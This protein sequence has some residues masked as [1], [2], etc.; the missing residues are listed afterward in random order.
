MSTLYGRDGEGGGGGATTMSRSACTSPT[1][2]GSSRPALSSC[3]TFAAAA[4]PGLAGCAA[5]CGARA[6]Q[7]GHEAL[8]RTK[9]GSKSPGASAV[10]LRTWKFE[11]PGVGG[12]GAATPGVGG[13]GVATPG[14]GGRGAA[15]PGVDAGGAAPA[16]GAAGRAG[17]AATTLAGRCVAPSEL[18]I[19]S[20]S[21]TLICRSARRL[22]GASPF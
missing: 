15:T 19:V 8:G 16:P 5:L 7:R 1:P 21:C 6:G 9:N 11:G 13:G 12:G 17:V 2:Y 18:G 10:K 4:G 22:S 20:G 3:S 14:V